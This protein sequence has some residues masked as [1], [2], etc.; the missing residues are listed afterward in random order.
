MTTAAH[1]IG[2]DLHKT[3]VRVCVLN[4]RG[5]VSEELRVRLG[6]GRWPRSA[7]ASGTLEIGLGTPDGDD[8]DVPLHQAKRFQGRARHRGAAS[9]R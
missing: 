1:F 7:A 3:V 5:G 2:I 4:E 8:R 9:A 6:T